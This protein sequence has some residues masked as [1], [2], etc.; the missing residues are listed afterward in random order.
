MIQLDM[1][2]FGDSYQWLS[3]VVATNALIALICIDVEWMQS[4]KKK[5]DH[6]YY[7][8][9]IF[10]IKNCPK[11]FVFYTS[12]FTEICWDWCSWLNGNYFPNQTE[13]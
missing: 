6:Y 12:V 3:L 8:Y 13:V 11:G 5:M 1:Y 4:K 10:Y 2:S 9:F 7:Y